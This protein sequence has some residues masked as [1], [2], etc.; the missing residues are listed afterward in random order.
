MTLDEAAR[1]LLQRRELRSSLLAWS[2]FALSPLSHTPARHH[3]L[4]IRELETLTHGDNDRLMIL[5]PPGSAKSTY[6][7]TIFPPWF[8]AQQEQTAVI[9]ASHTAELAERFGRRCRNLI[10]EHSAALGYGLRE[11]S[12]AAGRWDTTNGGEYFAIGVGGAVAGRRASLLVCDDPVRSRAEA[13]SDLVS[14]RTWDWWQSDVL[15]RLKPGAKVVLVM[16]RWSDKD[17]GGRIEQDMKEGGKPWRILR[18]PMEAEIDDPLGRDPGEMLWQEWFTP[19]MLAQAKRDTRTYSALYQQRPVPASGDYFHRDWLR[20]IAQLPPLA[21]LRIVMG[22]DY[23]VTSRGGDYTVHAVMG[24]DADDRLYLID[25]WR[26]QTSSDVWVDAWCDFVLRYKPIGAAEETGQIKSAIG[27]W[28]VKRQRERQAYTAREQFPTKGDKATRAQSI[29]GRMALNGL[30]IPAD[31]PWRADV[32]AELLSF[33]AGAHDDVCDAIGLCGLLMDKLVPPGRVT[34]MQPRAIDGYERRQRR[35]M[36]D[37]A[38]KV[39]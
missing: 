20:P 7:S 6:V 36:D 23:A 29:R 28:L 8:M 4:I 12:A 25:V 31:A 9:G 18:L 35:E 33:P 19:D 22:S 10:V 32:E 27:P 11:D 16:T 17:L 24:V 14:E 2:T 34:P 39:A 21:S 1:E 26:Q 30:Y 15:T 37:D 5:A 38:W 3:R 13:D